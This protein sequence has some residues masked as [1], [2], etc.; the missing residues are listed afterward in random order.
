MPRHQALGVSLF[1]RTFILLAILLA[2]GVFAWLQTL[3][4][5]EF[6]PRAIQAAQQTAGLVNLAR[7]ALKIAGGQ[8]GETNHWL[9]SPAGISEADEALA[10]LQREY[11]IIEYTLTL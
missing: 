11:S 3:R 8:A 10:G 2:G 5:L 4:A 1:W 9:F 7:A 6:E